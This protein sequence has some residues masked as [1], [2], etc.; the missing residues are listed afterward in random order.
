LPVSASLTATAAA[1]A[2]AT[3][4]STPARP[5]ERQRRLLVR[6]RQEPRQLPWFLWGARR[7]LQAGLERRAMVL[8]G[9]Q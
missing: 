8:W 1:R 9:E 4:E 5:H 2:L 3:A 6:V 7:L